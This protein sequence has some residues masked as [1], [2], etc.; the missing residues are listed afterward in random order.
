MGSLL[1][2][3][4]GQRFGACRWV[5][6][7][8]WVIHPR[9]FSVNEILCKVAIVAFRDSPAT[10]DCGAFRD[11]TRVGTGETPYTQR[12]QFGVVIALAY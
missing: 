9:S 5:L 11:M 4:R 7:R 10:K 3:F 2:A 12:D 6:C 1:V 8:G